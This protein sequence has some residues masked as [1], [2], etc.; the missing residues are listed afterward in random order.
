M[1]SLKPLCS[2]ERSMRETRFPHTVH[3]L[4]RTLL[5][6]SAWTRLHHHWTHLFRS[7]PELVLF[8]VWSLPRPCSSLL[9]ATTVPA[10]LDWGFF[11]YRTLLQIF[12]LLCYLKFRVSSFCLKMQFSLFSINFFS[13]YCFP[14]TGAAAI[15]QFFWLWFCFL[16][17]LMF[18]F[19][20]L[21]PFYIFLVLE[22]Q[23]EELFFPIWFWCILSLIFQKKYLD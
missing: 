20:F 7:R 5:A 6:F 18:S 21:V 14:S 2:L 9:E 13:C 1:F 16:F 22:S 23:L 3:L 19:L 8:F 4:H 17:S 12:L 10:T 15:V 11:F